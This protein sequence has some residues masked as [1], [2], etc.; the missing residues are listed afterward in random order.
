MTQIDLTGK[1][2][3]LPVVGEDLLITSEKKARQGWKEAV[4]KAI[5][6]QEQQGITPLDAPADEWL[7]ATLTD[8]EDECLQW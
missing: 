7:H 8:D 2:T 6:L 3:K 1:Q 5:A 4:E